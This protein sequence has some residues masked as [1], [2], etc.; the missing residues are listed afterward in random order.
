M[1][2]TR[3]AR[4]AL[5]L[6]LLLVAAGCA[7]STPGAPEVPAAPPAAEAP[8][9]P[10]PPPAAPADARAEEAPSAA[11]AVE[12]GRIRDFVAA[13]M[14]AE[15]TVGLTIGFVRDDVVWVEG[16]GLA[17]LENRVPAKPESSYRMASVTKP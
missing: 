13:R 1:T 12:I 8:A 11:H 2:K 3:N 16:F 15:G 5:A 6:S 14:E 10:A 7:T 17:D 9:A 4:L